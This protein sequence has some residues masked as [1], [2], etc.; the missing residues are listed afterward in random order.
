MA[1]GGENLLARA[2]VRVYGSDRTAG[3]IGFGLL[4]A[5]GKVVTCA[6]VVA[7][8]VGDEPATQSPPTGRVLLD[9]P[10]VAAGQIVTAAIAAWQART[11]GD[12][13]DVA[14]LV[15]DVS[16]PAGT[17]PVS[18]TRGG[19]VAGHFFQAY[20]YRPSFAGEMPTWV[21]GRI[22][23]RT[24]GNWLQLG[25]AE[26]TGGL[27]IHA[28]FSGT[29]VWDEQIGQVV[30]LVTAGHRG[31]GSRGSQQEWLAYAVSGETIFEAWPELRDSFRRACP[32]RSL[33][34]FASADSQLFFGR[35]QLA[36]ETAAIITGSE[37]TIVSGASGA[38]KT[39]L[40]QAGV[41]PQL[42]RQG[43]AVI[44]VRPLA[45]DSLWTE[46]AAAIKAGV[47][48]SDL[49]SAELAT[50]FASETLQ[51]RIA[52]LCDALGND[53]VVVVA[54]QYDE[55]LRADPARAREFTS[56]LG[57]LPSIRH[58]EG[59]PCVRVVIVVREDYE[60]H[61]RGLP[62]YD[63]CATGAV[64]V[65]PLSPDQLRTAIEGPVH[66]SGFAR[67]EETLVDRIVDEV[68][69]Q[70]YCLPALQVILTE[71]W[72][73]QD[74]DGLLRH[75]VYQELNR[76]PGP[77]AT[78]LEKRWSEL[79]GED[80]GAALH[81]FLHLAVPV[82]DSDFAR[83]TASQTEVSPDDWRIAGSLATQRLVVLRSAPDGDPTAE[84]AH[85]A[86]LDQWP[87]LTQHLRE[88]RDFLHWRDDLRRRIEAWEQAGQRPNQLLTGSVLKHALTRLAEQPADV[89]KREMEFLRAS[90][91][92]RRRVRRVSVLSVASI[93]TVVI[94]LLSFALL[95]GQ[96]AS[97]NRRVALS[98]QLAA[99][100]GQ[101]AS[102]NPQL[103]ALLSVAAYKISGTSEA[104][105]SLAQQ[106]GNLEH[107]GKFI[108]PGKPVSGL[109][110]TPGGR[111]LVTCAGEITI[112]D[113]RN[114][115]LAA[116]LPHSG[117]TGMALSPNG[118]MLAVIDK[119]TPGKASVSIWDM[120]SLRRITTLPNESGPVV[121]SP[122]S[123]LLAIG[124]FQRTKIGIWDVAKRAITV[125]LAVAAPPGASYPVSNGNVAIAFSPDSRLLAADSTL[126]PTGPQVGLITVVWDLRTRRIAAELEGGHTRGVFSLAFSPDGRILASGGHDA[127]IAFWNVASGHLIAT[128]PADG[129][130]NSLAF[131]PDG[132]T[133]ASAD[134]GGHVILWDAV[135]H[136]RKT[137]FTGHTAAVTN[138][139]FSPDGRTLASGG[140]DSRII[141]WNLTAR[142]Y[143]AST[144]IP[145]ATGPV[146]FAR[147]GQTLA[148]NEGDHVAVW[149]VQRHN[150]IAVFPSKT[151]LLGFTTRGDLALVDANGDF[152]LWD[153]AH[154]HEF[155]VALPSPI[156][157]A[158][159]SPDGRTLAYVP[160]SG[161][162]DQVLLWNIAQDTETGVLR[163]Q[164]WHGATPSSLAFSAD[165]ATLAVG[166]SGTVSLW[167]LS[168][169]TEASSFPAPGMPTEALAFSPDGRL[170]AATSLQS[171]QTTLGCAECY[172][173]VWDLS[174]HAQIATITGFTYEA[175]GVAFSPDGNILAAASPGEVF[176]WSTI[177]RAK[178]ITLPAA[179][180]VAFSPS[181]T[182]LATSATWKIGSGPAGITL[183]TMNAGTWERRICAIVNRNLTSAE[184]AT[185]L[186]GYPYQRQCGQ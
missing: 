69:V 14:G 34:H 176:L 118:R 184:W 117:C 76:A 30:G 123:R 15:L 52:R 106:L 68:G 79:T 83:R 177:Q 98:R 119:R 17:R 31:S 87:T 135:R 39:S 19:N 120:A 71:L 25:I 128:V 90:R 11:N 23:G 186:S 149:G 185:Y 182:I 122:D 55:L 157:V 111:S 141:L 167:N 1:D 47:N 114:G 105:A 46:L 144:T 66:R 133:L 16:E 3:P 8:A 89:S 169:Q 36:A 42:E 6:H 181:G 146:S 121:F 91:A 183:W 2:L 138:V 60:N 43:H 80:Q 113:T 4:V 139:T 97:Q 64:R 5:P 77:L 174:Q 13:D 127:R 73:R 41:I 33:T 67:Y 154:N 27:R 92:R 150:R 21:P 102:T 50:A 159:L 137:T 44:T 164:I 85:D 53:R 100:S 147:N 115:T 9:F 108:D 82:G 96:V 22:I 61:L 78:H 18:L 54:D 56:D 20:G 170:L 28:G 129:D 37:H 35:D 112:W 84:L 180:P 172:V 175:Y 59:R 156:G 63:T 99:T 125:T 62:P 72:E 10:F 81:L 12:S 75:S 163:S 126:T 95:Q 179:S 110:F 171:A 155:P 152:M 107:I 140:S 132:R 88:H 166:S 136:T 103:A 130:V 57:Q 93:L 131:S 70:P 101:L 38:G 161:N 48:R 134:G 45:R 58:P 162:T 51:S 116:T 143:M 104:Q 109:A 26:A 148:A 49:N 29:P 124:G 40:V 168:D 7:Q 160:S 94:A 32:F 24:E 86:L 158:A 165:G 65:G 145:D 74:A 151:S 142:N 153:F 178:I 173:V